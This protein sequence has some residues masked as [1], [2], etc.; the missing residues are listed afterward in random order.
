VLS[1]AEELATMAERPIHVALDEDDFCTLVAGGVVEKPGVRIILSD[2]GFGV[3][4]KHL[5]D[6]MMRVAART[7]QLE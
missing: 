6:T 5:S 2:I 7:R 3:M 1:A 4:V